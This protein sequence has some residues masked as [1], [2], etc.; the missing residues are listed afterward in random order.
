M[1]STYLQDIEKPDDVKLSGFFILNIETIGLFILLFLFQPVEQFLSVKFLIM[2]PS[3]MS[4]CWTTS[5]HLITSFRLFFL[6]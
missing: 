5:P 3:F 1:I 6:R 4:G 2:F